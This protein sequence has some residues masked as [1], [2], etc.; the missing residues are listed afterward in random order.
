MTVSLFRMARRW[1]L[2]YRHNTRDPPTARSR[3]AFSLNC[4]R[5][6]RRDDPEGP[7]SRNERAPVSQASGGHPGGVGAS[8]PHAGPSYRFPRGW[9][10]LIESTEPLRSR[11]LQAASELRQGV[12][13]SD[14]LLPVLSASRAAMGE[15]G[16]CGGRRLPLSRPFGEGAE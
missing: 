9:G 13:E 2:P 14:R 15:Q 12:A 3:R 11:S 5:S 6:G 10:R 16:F 1:S 4:T 7:T 8:R